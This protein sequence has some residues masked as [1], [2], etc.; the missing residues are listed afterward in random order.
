MDAELLKALPALMAHPQFAAVSNA[1]GELELNWST[2]ETARQA[3]DP[4]QIAAANERE[5]N[6]RVRLLLAALAAPAPAGAPDVP[7]VVSTDDGTVEWRLRS[8]EGVV[9]SDLSCIEYHR[10]GLDGK[11]EW[12]I[13]GASHSVAVNRERIVEWARLIGFGP[14][15][16]PAPDVT[17]ED[18]IATVIWDNSVL[19]RAS[20]QALARAIVEA[21][22]A[23][24]GRAS[25]TRH[26]PNG[27]TNV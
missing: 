20:C 14:Q 25:A 22:A 6:S 5:T 4:E 26:A 9:R 19:E 24:G 11:G 16:S 13:A 3:G 17:D 10:P 15:V 1:L 7:S 23:K 27:E 12:F 21:L 8:T 2:R 18:E